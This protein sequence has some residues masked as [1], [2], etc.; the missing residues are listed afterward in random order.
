MSRP[1]FTKRHFE[2]IAAIFR[3]WTDDPCYEDD[4]TCIARDFADLFGEHNERFDREKFLSA[5][6]LGSEG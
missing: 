5:C 4:L 6:G 1:V 2:A 3:A